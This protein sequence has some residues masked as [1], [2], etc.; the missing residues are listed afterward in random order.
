[1]MLNSPHID[2]Q[3]LTVNSTIN[4]AQHMC[5]NKSIK[6]VVLIHHSIHLIRPTNSFQAARRLTIL[7]ASHFLLWGGCLTQWVKEKQV[8]LMLKWGFEKSGILTLFGFGEFSKVSPSQNQKVLT[9]A[10]TV[11]R[12][13]WFWAISQTFHP[14]LN[15]T[16]AHKD[17][18][19]VIAVTS[20][21]AFNELRLMWM[22]SLLASY[23]RVQ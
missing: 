4:N 10:F 2:F 17:G 7:F 9:W 3:E 14:L 23:S 20:Q 18:F 8:G 11:I 15:R 19:N 12:V 22:L 13:Y 21:L 1:M 6:S 16:P 5:N